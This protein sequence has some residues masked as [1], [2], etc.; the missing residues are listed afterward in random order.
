MNVVNEIL[1]WFESAG[2]ITAAL[3]VDKKNTRTDL[4][5]SNDDKKLM[6]MRNHI[7]IKCRHYTLLYLNNLNGSH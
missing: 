5:Y 6:K 1:T 4:K 7:Q 3:S 2:P